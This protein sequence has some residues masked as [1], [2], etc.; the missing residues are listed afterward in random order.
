MTRR[1]RSGIDKQIPDIL[2]PQL[3]DYFSL[4]DL[5]L[6]TQALN[7]GSVLLTLAPKETFPLVEKSLLQPVYQLAHSPLVSG[8]AL[9]ALT[10]FY[11]ALVVADP[12]IATRVVPG[13][14]AAIEKHERA[15]ASPENVSKCISAVVRG[16]PAIAAGV[17]AE[18]SKAIKVR[19]FQ[20]S[21]NY[22]LI[23]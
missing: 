9:E 21:W 5:V 22:F 23:V 3:Q 14:V 4:Q 7:T 15:E 6:L 8:S 17:I 19:T 10:N 11:C 18:F 12:E 13:L 20:E 1:F 2:V 16:S